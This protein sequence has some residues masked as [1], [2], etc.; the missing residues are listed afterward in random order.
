[1]T[2]RLIGADRLAEALAALV[3]LEHRH[4][5]TVAADV[6]A[7]RSLLPTS[8]PGVRLRTIGYVA[9]A[10]VVRFDCDVDLTGPFDVR[11]PT[12]EARATLDA[13]RSDFDGICEFRKVAR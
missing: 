2:A 7:L 4:R 6:D 13:L 12:A 11:V 3:V 10:L 1:M 9:G 5:T 8:T